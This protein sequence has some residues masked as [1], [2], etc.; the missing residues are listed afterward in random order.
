MRAPFRRG[1]PQGGRGPGARLR[2]G[3]PFSQV[4]FSKS[5][6]TLSAEDRASP[7]AR[8]AVAPARESLNRRNDSPHGPSSHLRRGESVS[9]GQS[10]TE[11]IAKSLSV[12]GK[13]LRHSD[14]QFPGLSLYSA[15]E[16]HLCGSFIWTAAESVRIVPM[17]SGKG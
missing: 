6:E 4:K 17:S 8:R 1:S 2:R 13:S 12:P 3:Q 15:A 11:L 7:F 14:S 5:P 10:F 16:L 9:A